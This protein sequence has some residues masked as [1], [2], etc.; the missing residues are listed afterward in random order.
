MHF[1]IHGLGSRF[2]PMEHQ[3]N[4]SYASLKLC[5]PVQAHIFITC[6]NIVLRYVVAIPTRYGLNLKTITNRLSI[7]FL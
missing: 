3:N 6:T 4:K 5:R 1:I 7:P 2:T